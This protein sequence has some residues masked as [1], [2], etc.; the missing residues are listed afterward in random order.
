MK[1]I[2]L[3]PI[4]YQFRIDELVKM[5]NIEIK[6]EPVDEFVTREFRFGTVFGLYRKTDECLDVIAVHNKKPKNGHF[7]LFVDEM[8]RIA[9]K[10]GKK[11]RFMFMMNE[12]LTRH[13]IEDRGFVR[14]GE[15][16]E[17]AAGDIVTF[18]IGRAHV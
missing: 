16:C 10:E 4:N 3:G 9:A 2:D 18:E 8:V 6:A 13:L 12:R 11:L 14:N 17:Y 15:H 1:L 7:A 5:F